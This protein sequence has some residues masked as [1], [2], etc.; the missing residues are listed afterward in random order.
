[1]YPS[2]KHEKK[3]LKN[4]SQ[5]KMYKLNIFYEGEVLNRM[6]SVLSGHWLLKTACKD[7]DNFF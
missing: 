5:E 6:R 2:D 4:C 1:M 7:L 3:I